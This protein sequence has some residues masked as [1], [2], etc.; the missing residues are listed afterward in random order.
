MT[1]DQE[2]ER[3]TLLGTIQ[4]NLWMRQRDKG[5]V[6]NWG[7]TGQS[8]PNA[9]VRP[10][11]HTLLTSRSRAHRMTAR[12][13]L[14]AQCPL[15]FPLVGLTLRQ[16]YPLHLEKKKKLSL[17]LEKGIVNPV[18]RVKTK[19]SITISFWS[20]SHPVTMFCNSHSEISLKAGVHPSILLPLY[21]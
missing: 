19:S 1:H 13:H 18:S 20:R 17:F 14:P 15:F 12:F 21:L 8:E 2:E 7:C 3:S 4:K 11:A 9:A 10:H 16:M 6:N 5:S